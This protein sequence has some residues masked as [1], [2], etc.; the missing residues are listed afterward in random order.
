MVREKTGSYF[1]LHGQRTQKVKKLRVAIFKHEHRTV[2]KL[3]EWQ[4]PGEHRLQWLRARLR[5]NN[6]TIT[7]TLRDS[8]HLSEYNKDT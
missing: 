7:N 2:R 4:E 8:I 6:Y 1:G 5:C 3:K